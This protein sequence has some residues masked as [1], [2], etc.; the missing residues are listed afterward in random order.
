[1][2]YKSILLFQ[3]INWVKT[4]EFLIYWK[5]ITDSKILNSI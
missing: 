4:N 5:D 3:F 2:G 1:L